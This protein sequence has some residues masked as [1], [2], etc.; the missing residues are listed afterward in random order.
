M[1]S[2]RSGRNEF[3]QLSLE[4]KGRGR[5]G[6]TGIMSFKP[7]RK[8]IFGNGKDLFDFIASRLRM[9]LSKK[10]LSGFER[11]LGVAFSFSVKQTGIASGKLVCW[12]KGF[13]AKDVIGKD[14]ANRTRPGFISL[15]FLMEDLS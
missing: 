9:F 2:A 6:K 5:I 13:S 7:G 15:E 11:A 4:L 12:T 8:E 14:V 10:N 3:S 1:H